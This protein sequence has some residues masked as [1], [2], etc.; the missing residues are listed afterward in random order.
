MESVIRTKEGDCQLL[1][2]SLFAVLVGISFLSWSLHLRQKQKQVTFAIN[3][4]HYFFC[5]ATVNLLQFDVRFRLICYIL[6]F[7]RPGHD[8][9]EKVTSENCRTHRTKT[10]IVRHK[11][12]CSA[13]TLTFASCITVSTT[14]RAE[15][16][17]HKAK[18]QSK[19]TARIVHK[20][21]TCEKDFHIIDLLREHKRMEYGGQRSPGAQNVDVTQLMGDDNDKS[22]KEELETYKHF[23][24]ERK[25]E[26]GSHTVFNFAMD[27]KGIETSV[28]KK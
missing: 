28:A 7:D 26:N 2:C 17:Y 16:K 18:K 11:T 4:R 5:N 8:R 21:K 20:F 24:V 3:L 23:L 1:I 19:A 15:R 27:T 9:N 6:N 10:N 25:M 12:R 14:S 13:G 22:P